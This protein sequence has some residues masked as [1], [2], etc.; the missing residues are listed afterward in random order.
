MQTGEVLPMTLDQQKRDHR[1]TEDTKECWCMPI[2]GSDRKALMVDVSIHFKP[3]TDVPVE[4]DSDV[5]LNVP[6]EDSNDEPVD[7]N[8]EVDENNSDEEDA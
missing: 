8:S 1:D 3:A 7:A 4:D 6:D 2:I 5:A